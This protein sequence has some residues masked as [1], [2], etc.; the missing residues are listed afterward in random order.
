MRSFKPI[1]VVGLLLCGMSL[2]GCN[3]QK[4]GTISNKIREL[5]SRHAKLEEDYRTLQAANEQHRKR[6][7]AVEAQRTV[8]E[9]DKAELAKQ[10][11]VATTERETLKKQIAQ[12][13]QE[14]DSA[15]SNLVQFSK[16]LQALAGRIE[17]AANPQV[18]P[19]ATIIPASRRTE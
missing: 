18:S 17:A 15:Q 9:A 8:L 5:E 11:D 12:R 7:N 3:Q 14:R 13:T 4:T 10:L 19:N 2:W 16:D 6:L 1:A